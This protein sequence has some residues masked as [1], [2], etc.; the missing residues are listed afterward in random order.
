MV[1]SNAI[2]HD[3]LKRAADKAALFLVEGLPECFA[4]S[5]GSASSSLKVLAEH[6]G[7]FR[8]IA[9]RH[10]ATRT[11]ILPH[12]AAMQRFLTSAEFFYFCLRNPGLF[13]LWASL[14][15]DLGFLLEELPGSHSRFIRSFPIEEFIDVEPADFRRLDAADICLRSG[16]SGDAVLHSFRDSVA[17]SSLISREYPVQRMDT[18]FVYYITHFTFYASRWGEATEDFSEEFHHNLAAAGRWARSVGDADLVS[19]CIVAAL[20]SGSRMECDELLEFVMGRRGA[21]GTIRREPSPRNPDPLSYEQARH[22]T[23]VGLW[24]ISEYAYRAGVELRLPL[25]AI[26]RDDYFAVPFESDEQEMAE[27]ENLI[28]NYSGIAT[29]DISAYERERAIQLAQ[30]IRGLRP[31]LCSEHYLRDLQ[32]NL[33]EIQRQLSLPRALMKALL[34]VIGGS[35]CD[36]CSRRLIHAMRTVV[37]ARP[38]DSGTEEWDRLYKMTEN[39]LALP[40]MQE[41]LPRTELAV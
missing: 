11:S 12:I 39:V 7:V 33:P 28:S 25:E 41:R 37:D 17:G 40:I 10:P 13:R 2:G 3:Q 9:K 16:I 32:D 1:R 5:G 20:H 4:A 26:K 6:L 27:L 35:Q 34:E 15:S 22:T 31:F 19:E 30:L 8:E 21:N 23:L 29:R 38:Q 24:A 14:L 18:S 36:E